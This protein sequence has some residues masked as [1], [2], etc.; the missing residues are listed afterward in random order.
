MNNS[1]KK[2][3]TQNDKPLLLQ[4]THQSKRVRE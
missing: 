3:H 1:A 4:Q 2:I